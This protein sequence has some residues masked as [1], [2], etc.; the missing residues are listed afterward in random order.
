MTL[1]KQDS[2]LSNGQYQGDLSIPT[3]KTTVHSGTPTCPMRTFPLQ[4][5]HSSLQ[6]IVIKSSANI[7]KIS[8]V[9]CLLS[10]FKN[11]L[12]L[13]MRQSTYLLQKVFPKWNHCLVDWSLAKYFPKTNEHSFVLR[14]G[15]NLDAD[16]IK[17]STTVQLPH[18]K[19]DSSLG[20]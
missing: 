8:K 18:D 4:T 13:V 9:C 16:F 3:H 7:T 17:V 12:F 2:V 15:M 10:L 5:E 11:F 20:T 1:A 6:T 19:D 14:A